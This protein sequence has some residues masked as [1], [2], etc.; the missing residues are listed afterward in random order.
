MAGHR[1]Q[2]PSCFT[3]VQIPA[4]RSLGPFFRRKGAVPPTDDQPASAGEV[5]LPNSTPLPSDESAAVDGGTLLP[6]RKSGSAASTFVPIRT[7]SAGLDPEA[8]AIS[9]RHPPRWSRLLSRRVEPRWYHSL[10]YPAANVPIFFRL[11]MMLTVLTAVALVGWLSI[12][13]DQPR[14]WPYEMLGVSLFLL[15]LVLGR[16]LNYFNAIVALAAQGKV[17][18]EAAID[19]APIQAILSCG[20]WLA[21]FL[22]GPAFL[23]GLALGYWLYSGDLTMIDWLILAEL[24]FAGVGWWLIAILLVNA[25]G[26]VRV[27]TP[28]QIMQTALAMRWKTVELALLATGVFLAHLF[29]AVY[30]IGHLHDRPLVAFALLCTAATTGLYLTAF[31]FRRL[32]LTYYRFERKRRAGQTPAPAG[33]V[34]DGIS[35]ATE[36]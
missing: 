35:R 24:G 18:H 28:R 21:C 17:K 14:N 11:A 16:T 6:R 27:P 9:L 15:L 5:A 8:T 20:Q 7:T 22:A 33:V 30:G 25:D 36:P 13:S 34:V 3:S 2:C 10:V 29:A 4:R 19:F 1:T 23:F 31:T 32:G 12:D 26:T